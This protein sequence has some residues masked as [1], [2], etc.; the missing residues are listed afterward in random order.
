MITKNY[1]NTDLEKIH[2]MCTLDEKKTKKT[3]NWMR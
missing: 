3:N 2:I 1:N